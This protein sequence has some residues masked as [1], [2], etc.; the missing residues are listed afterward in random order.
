[1]V[2]FVFSIGRNEISTSSLITFWFW[3]WRVTGNIDNWHNFTYRHVISRCLVGIKA[4]IVIPL[5]KPKL[6]L[7]RRIIILPSPWHGSPCHTNLCI[8]PQI[9]TELQ[10]HFV[11]WKCTSSPGSH[12]TKNRTCRKDLWA[13][14]V[15]WG[16]SY[17]YF[18]C[19]GKKI[20]TRSTKSTFK[21]TLF[22]FFKM[23]NVWAQVKLCWQIQANREIISVWLNAEVNT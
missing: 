11:Y 1:M 19:G 6:K 16:V 3:K 12:A 5:I 17:F 18:P 21:V 7:S 10:G 4:V 20:Q 8:A 2:L 13:A 9:E 22:I 14:F 15:L 23:L